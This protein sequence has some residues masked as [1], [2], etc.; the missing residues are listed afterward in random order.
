M[1]VNAKMI[2]AETVPGTRGGRL[3]ENSGWGNSTMMYLI[4]CMNLCKWY[5]VPSHSTIIK[6][7]KFMFKELPPPYTHTLLILQSCLS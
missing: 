2:P 1:C 5:N 4:H 6:K 7:I 3:K